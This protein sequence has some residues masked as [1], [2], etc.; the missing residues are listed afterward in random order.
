MEFH[1]QQLVLEIRPDAQGYELQFWPDPD[2]RQESD[3][4]RFALT[5][6]REGLQALE[7]QIHEALETT[8]G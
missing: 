5:L 2:S 8:E 3:A 1:Y 6:T 7:R 4:P